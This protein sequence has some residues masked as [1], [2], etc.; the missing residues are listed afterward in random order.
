MAN[1]RGKRGT[2]NRFHLLGLQDHCRRWLQSWNQ[3]S[4]DYCFLAGKRWQTHLD[5]VLKSRDITL[6]IKVRIVKAMIFPV[7]MYGCDSWTVQKA[8]RQRTDAFE[9]WCWKRL[10]KVPWAA[11]R[12]N[13][14][15]W[16][17]FN[18]EYSLQG[19]KLKPQYFGHLMCTD[20]SLEKSP[21]LGKI[22]GRRRRGRQRMRWGITS[23]MNMNLGKLQE[24]V[25]DREA[26]C[27]TVHVVT[28][29]RTRLGDWTTVTREGFHSSFFYL[30]T[31]SSQVFTQMPSQGA[32]FWSQ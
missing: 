29:I 26:W 25:R 31:Q 24:M 2:S 22:E 5:S 32:F 10:L 3:K 30:V 18:P 12:S 23:A 4:E 20:D 8:E 6:P 17:D 11:G 16:R 21:I 13:Q 19:L 1:R 9:L 28:K 15:L 7:V 14:S 27:A